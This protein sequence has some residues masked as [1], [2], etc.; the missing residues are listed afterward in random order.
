M[1]VQT[2]ETVTSYTSQEPSL[3]ELLRGY[4]FTVCETPEEAAEALAVRREV[5]AESGYSVPCPDEYD[6]RSWLLRAED[7]RTGR[8]V[9]TMRLTPRVAGPFESEE[10]FRL[11]RDLQ[12]P[13]GLEIS[14]FAIL[15][16]YRRDRMLGPAISFGLFKLCYEFALAVGA[17]Y[18]VVCSKPERAWT[19]TSM[20]FQPTGITAPY[21]KLNGAVHELLRV[22]FREAPE[23]LRDNPFKILFLESNFSEVIVPSR[24]PPLGLVPD[25]RE[26]RFAVG[27]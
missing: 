6:H 10:Y 21:T 17:R 12:G 5:Y 3:T 27:A 18:E 2:G 26:F 4:R 23:F 13:S 19:Y 9:G 20:G 14:R 15:A 11:S 22:D 1:Q 25:T 16:A 8:C 7:V 24:R